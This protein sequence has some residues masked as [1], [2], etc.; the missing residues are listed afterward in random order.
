MM[1]NPVMPV[2]SPTVEPG[3]VDVGPTLPPGTWNI[4][5]ASPMRL[6]IAG[7]AK[8]L[9]LSDRDM[10]DAAKVSCSDIYAITRRNLWPVRKDHRLIAD[11]LRAYLEQCGASAADVAALFCAP[12]WPVHVK[13]A[14]NVKAKAAPQESE[15]DMLLPKQTLTPQ[16]ARHFKL[17]R[18][19]FDGPVDRDEQFFESD[20]VRHVRETLWQC[21]RNAG[22]TALIGESGAGKTT[23]LADLEERLTKEGRDVLLFKPGVLGMEES[24]RAGKML[25]SADILSAVISSLDPLASMPQQLQARSVLAHK[26]LSASAA[27]G[28]VHLVVIEEAHG[29]PDST[30]KHLKRMHEMRQGRRS[31]LGI[32]LLAQTELKR[33]LADGL[34]AGTLREVAQRC[35][36]VELMPLGRDLRAYLECRSS[37]CGK[38]LSALMDAEAVEQLRTRLTKK[39]QQGAV[40]LTYPLVVG[41]ACTRA[42]NIAAELGVPLVTA[43]VMRAI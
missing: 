30:M 36:I 20:E 24:D 26:L 31:L 4:A 21:A 11:R 7:V 15:P 41:N 25:K 16:A 29:L 37:A 10:A 12:L 34:R 13:K 23:I 33:R 1:M 43:D 2:A 19:P 35:E 17:F 8:A 5:P 32:L 14:K 39:L 28:N 42:M 6:H 40:D 9:S 27:I 38:P 3:P 22:F 18:N